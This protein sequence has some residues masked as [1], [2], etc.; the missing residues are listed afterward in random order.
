MRRSTAHFLLTILTTAALVLPS[1]T[2][3]G[4][5]TTEPDAVSVPG[6][7]GSEAGCAADWSADCDQ[8][9]LHRRADGD[10]STT[11]TLPAGSYE[12]KVAIDKSWNENYGAGGAAGGANITL[13]V[14]ADHTTVTFA[15]D[16]VTHYA[17]TDAD[18]PIAV[19]VG[20][21]Q[22]ELG[23]SSDWAPDCLKSWLTDPDG[24]GIATFTTS[25]IPA[26]DWQVK[27][28]TNLS[29][30]VNYGKDG[31][32]SGENIPFTVAKTGDRT[33]FSYNEGTHVL[34]VLAGNGLPS[35]R[36]LGGYWLS[37]DTIAWKPSTDAAI[38]SYAL[39]AAPDGGLT[40]TPTG[41]DGGTRF[42][43]TAD[44]AGL[45]TSLKTTFPAQAGLPALHLD[46]TTAAKAGDLLTGQ[47]AVAAFDAD[48]RLVDATGLQTPGVLDD[49]D[50]GAAHRV[51][52]P[53]FTGATPSLAL[54]APTAQQVSVKLYDS[55]TATDPSSTVPLTRGADGVW[56]ATGTPAWTGNFYQYDVQVYVPE[57]ARVEH[58]LVTDPYSVALSQNSTRSLLA[59]LNSPALK[60]AGWNTLR[61]PRIGAPVDQTI[62]ELHVRDFSVGDPTVPAGDRGTYAAFGDTSSNAVKHLKSLARAGMTTVHLLPAADFAS[63]S[64]DEDKSTWQ[65]PNCD[66]P[67]YPP[68]S[69]Q[70]QACVTATADKDGYNWGYDPQHYTVPEGSYATDPQG[71]A[72]TREFRGM[73]S[74]L[75]RDGLRVVMDV[76]YNHTSDSGQAG[77]NDLDRIV[78]GYYHRLDATGKVTTSTCCSDTASEHTMMG[79]LL[80]DSV[81]TWA[82]QYKVDG[83]RF[84]LMSFT[85]KQV[86]VDLRKQLDALTPSKDGVDGKSIYLYGE[87]WNFGTVADN[88][89][90]TQAS[91]ANMGGTGVGTFN[92]RIRDAVRGGK[93]DDVDPRRQGW[94][95]GLYTDPNGDAVNGSVS[96]QLAALGNAE[97]LIKVGLTGNLADY[98]FTAANGKTVTGSQ[99]DY[100]GAPAGYTAEPQEAVNYV[101]AHD[102]E[103]LYD[104]LT[105]K[106]P[107]STS[108]ADRIRMQ[109]LAL[110][111]TALSQ[112]VSFWQAGT[113][114][115]RSKSFDG[116][117]YNSGDWFNALDPSL[118]TNGFGKGLPPAASNQ[119][120]W[121][122]AKPLL[123]DAK[124]KPTAADLATAESASEALLTIRK[125]SPLLHLGSAALIQQ[126]VSFPNSGASA[127]PGVIV[128]RID[129][130]VGPNVDR[131]RKGQVIVF[132][133]GTTATTQTVPAM[134]NA[135]VILNPVQ[136]LSKD[137]VVKTARFDRR[138]GTFTV[139]A[140]TVAVFD[141]F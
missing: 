105:Y 43:L 100:N 46:A 11:L 106:L 35:V 122:Y 107:Q 111:T 7:F 85:P 47:V 60:P 12:Y 48:G 73:V 116:N 50:A 16:P 18:H 36:K 118:S 49:I 59:D 128:E 31:V 110:S 126:K 54:W 90:F 103:T 66:L 1:A 80:V 96:D 102:N 129:D 68:A 124:L 57:T 10:W 58:N 130:T 51:L 17:S 71:A 44:P 61:K 21:F 38:A 14:P 89:L 39:Y 30:D 137:K 101:D 94:A 132:N 63:S 120:R 95:S 82:K 65:S 52:G 2:V 127:T 25:A 19:A 70:Q 42:P 22:S 62:S 81:L 8:V 141:Q 104:F 139:P 78:P 37:R 20:D 88:A 41:I 32:A 134:K 119:A 114:A 84:D 123:E 67:S 33:T 91:Q 136:L 99:V 79:K 83:F 109:T 87:G 26:G 133:A 135:R 23:C 9:Q 40:P 138:T 140:R 55:A 125:T 64:V 97:D 3:A 27:T 29:W 72:R 121:P 56:T 74:N 76:V 86:I 115:L 113:E 98:R 131:A 28:A 112:G 15:Y 77:T 13:T 45:P 24:D 34:S 6:S 53:T 93:F 117:S 75:N 69:D 108:M 5:A 4:A 92:D